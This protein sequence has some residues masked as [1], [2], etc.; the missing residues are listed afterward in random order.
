MASPASESKPN[1]AKTTPVSC[2]VFGNKRPTTDLLESLE[3]EEELDEELEL[4]DEVEL[5]EL[6]D[7][8]LEDELDELLELEEEL[9]DELLEDELE[10]EEGPVVLGEVVVPVPES[11]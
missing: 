2:P 4:D 5:E 3:F 8:L 7:E 1:V 6:E 9:E 10:L 11:L